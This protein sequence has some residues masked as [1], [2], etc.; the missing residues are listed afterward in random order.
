[1]YFKFLTALVCLLIKKYFPIKL[2]AENIFEKHLVHYVYNV[3]YYCLYL[4]L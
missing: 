4:D 3:L 2:H 1:M